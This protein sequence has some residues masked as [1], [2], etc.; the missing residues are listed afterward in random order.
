V[1]LDYDRPNGRTISIAVARAPAKDPANRIGSLFVNPGGPGA[2]GVDFVAAATSVGFFD[3]LNQRFDIVGFDPRGVG[4]STPSIDCDVNQETDGLYSQPFPTPLTID[5]EFVDKVRGYGA[6]CARLN[7]DILEHVST[8]DVARDMDVLRE[9]VG[10]EKLSYLGFSYGTFLGATYASLFPERYRALV[11]DGALD[12]DRFINEPLVA[13]RIQTAAFER[14]LGRFFE[15][16]AANQTA[17]LGFGGAD[18]H[19]AFDQLVERA[20]ATPIPATGYTPDPRPIDGDDLKAAAGQ[21]TYAKELWALLAAALATAQ[22]GDGTLVRAIVDE[23]F[24]GRDPVTGDYDPGLDRFVAIDGAEAKWPEDVRSYLR[25]GSE[26]WDM[27]DNVYWN[28]GYADLS[29]GLWPAEAQDAFYGPF[30]VPSSAVTPLVIGT[31]YDPATPYRG[32][33][34]LTHELGNARLLTM[35]GDGHTAY[36]GQS[37]CIDAA[38]E[39]YLISGTLPAAGTSCVQQIPFEPII[40]V[41]SASGVTAA[42]LAMRRATQSRRLGPVLRRPAIIR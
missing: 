3:T 7:G 32:A 40:P 2:P 30:R 36:G 17:C 41:A 31:T 26:S 1:P 12:A 4:Q 16:C 33:I 8:A 38:V 27:F 5:R 22:A 34:R 39:A 35:R 21:A 23:I 11:L 25:A 18:P 24:Y 28:H 9:A 37:P 6:R 20:D 29:F 10:D 14:A 15:A 42:R 19:D 13:T